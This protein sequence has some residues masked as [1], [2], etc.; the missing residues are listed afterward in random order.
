VFSYGAATPL[1]PLMLLGFP[2]MTAA[3]FMLV[4][5]RRAVLWSCLIA[6]LFLPEGAYVFRG[7]PEYSKYSA[8]SVVLLAAIALDGGRP[9][10][11]RLSWIDLPMAVW[12]IGRVATSLSNDLGLYDGL[13]NMLQ[14][15]VM[16]GLPYWLGRT[17]FS[18]ADGIRE[19]A[20][21]IVIGGL[22]YL[23]LCLFEVRFSPQLHLNVYGYLTVPFYLLQRYG[24]YRPMVFMD[25]SLQVGMW[26]SAATVVAWWLGGSGAVKRVLGVPTKWA[27]WALL[28]TTILCKTAGAIT[29]ALVGILLFSTARIGKRAL[30]L[31]AALIV[32]GSYPVIRGLGILDAE[33]ILSAAGT[34]Y[35]ADRLRSLGVR[36]T[37]EDM[38]IDHAAERPLFGWGGYG[39]GDVVVEGLGRS[40]PDGLWVIALSRAGWLAVAALIAMYLL[41][42]YL[43]IR[44]ERAA[45]WTRPGLA[46]AAALS[47]LL[48]LYWVDCLSNAMVTPVLVVAMGAGNGWFASARIAAKGAAP[49]PSEPTPPAAGEVP[50]PSRPASLARALT[51]RRRNRGSGSL[52]P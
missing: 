1:V 42:A 37:S 4:P 39:R 41:P 11:V 49:A 46:P 47:V 28:V 48:V 23:P 16:F 43:L 5:P 25:S 33:R 24:G 30:P 15:L 32:V 52:G 9:L 13:S 20:Q 26:M 3:L 6:A 17:Y 2:L 18:D 38:Y 19:L 21:G 40:I 7:L 44:R 31:A 34:V 50:K 12:C 8:L 22:L 27:A 10:R 36:L 29:L 51:E 45:A 35:D 14:W